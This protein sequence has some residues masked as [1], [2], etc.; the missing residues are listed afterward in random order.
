MRLL[1]QHGEEVWPSGLSPTFVQLRKQSEVAN[2]LCPRNDLGYR[3]GVVNMPCL[4]AAQVW[5]DQVDQ[6][7][8]DPG[9]IHELRA[10]RVFD[11][12]WFDEAYN[13]TV[14]RYLSTSSA[15]S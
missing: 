15:D 11:P 4:L 5:T 13:L 8:A 12:E 7:F 6:W 10:Y 1:R 14:A 2:F 9:A 3:D